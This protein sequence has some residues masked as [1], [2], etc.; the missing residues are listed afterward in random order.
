MASILLGVFLKGET[1]MKL[2][3]Y[4]YAPRSMNL[5]NNL[6]Q[7]DQEFRSFL[8][9][10]WPAT[11]TAFR[12]VGL[13]EGVWSPS[14]DLYEDKDKL[15][16]KVELPGLKK[17]EFN[18]SLQGDALIIK[19]E[20]KKDHDM[21]MENYHR[22]ERIYGPFQRAVILPVPVDGSGITATYRNGLLEVI[23][24]KKEEVKTKE[25]KV[26]VSL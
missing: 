6:H 20:R 14:V 5:F 18:L 25:I 8:E 2:I 1:K 4:S 23:L 3:Q 10:T 24:P 19:G 15:R 26:D 11:S 22:V 7:L 13:L 12:T 16:V 9:E 17:G 21:N